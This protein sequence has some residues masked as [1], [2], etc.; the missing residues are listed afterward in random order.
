MAKSPI[1]PGGSPNW[2][3]TP[4]QAIALQ[5]ELAGRVR[6]EPLP[7][8]ARLVAGADVSVLKAK[9]QL[10]AGIVLWDLEDQR[11][12]EQVAVRAEAKF[13]YVPGLLS[14]REAPAVLEAFGQLRQRPD[15]ALFDGQ[16]YAHP[17][18]FGLACHLGVLLD[19]PCVG[20]A[21]S[22]LIGEFVQP[23][24]PRGSWS[25]LL[26]AEEVIGAVL[27]TRDRVSPLYISIGH[28]ADLPGSIDLVLRCATLYRLP[29]PTRLAHQLVTRE[30]AAVNSSSP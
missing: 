15:V 30:K 4:R 13:P 1:K 14:F 24:A 12:V 26:H 19:L 5:K 10:I 20:C 21:K 7:K 18:R 3:L 25:N 27:R 17:R 16:G 2:D 11:V 28:R 22:R 9:N 8:G 6:V 23:A 29:E